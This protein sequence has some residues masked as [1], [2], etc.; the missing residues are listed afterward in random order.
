MAGKKATASRKGV[1]P[2]LVGR[3]VAYDIKHGRGTQVGG[4]QCIIAK[5]CDLKRDTQWKM[6]S[7]YYI[8]LAKR[9]TF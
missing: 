9:L 6:A 8:V 3:E 2:H 1:G 4:S 7:M 5:F